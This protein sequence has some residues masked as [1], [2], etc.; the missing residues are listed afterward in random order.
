MSLFVEVDSVEKGCKVIVNIDH[1]LEIAP[2]RDGGCTL[3]MLDGASTAG[4]TS[5]RVKDSYELFKQFAMQ[6]VTGDMIK[7]RIQK[8]NASVPKE[9]K[10]PVAIEKEA[11]QSKKGGM[12]TSS[13]LNYEIPKL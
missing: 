6:T 1:I 2:M 5:M 10:S 13:D 3:F 4:K 11:K 9:M 12:V 8:I 7:D